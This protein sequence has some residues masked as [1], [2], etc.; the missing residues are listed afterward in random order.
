MDGRGS[1]LRGCD[2][3]VS[4]RSLA[5]SGSSPMN[6]CYIKARS[7]PPALEH[8][9]DSSSEEEDQSFLPSSNY[10]PVIVSQHRNI[11]RIPRLEEALQENAYGEWLGWLMAAIYMGGRIP[12]I[13]LSGLNP[14]MF[15]FALIANA[16]YVGRFFTLLSLFLT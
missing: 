10:K 14:L 4:A 7:G 1:Q 9:S 3:H 11:P 2:H 13:W 16:T 12:Q 5:G 8:D 15:V 6:Q